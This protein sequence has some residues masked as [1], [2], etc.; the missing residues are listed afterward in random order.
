MPDNP[1][2]SVVL[3]TYRRGHHIKPTIESVLGQTFS[4]FELIVVGDGCTDETESA[5]RSFAHEKITWRNLPYNTGSQT[6][7]NNEGTHHSRG[8]WICYL[9]HDDIWSPDHLECLAQTIASGDGNDFVVSGCIF[10]GPKDSGYYFV[11]GLFDAPDAPFVHFFPLTSLAHRRDIPQRIGGWRDP[12]EITLPVDGD[13]LL[14]AARAGLRFTSTGRITVH[15]FA[16][17][18][19]YLSYLRPC[20]DEQR[21]MMDLLRTTPEITFHEIIATSKRIGHFMTTGYA[22]FT[23]RVPGYNFERNRENKGINIPALQPLL[24]RT[25]LGQTEELRA[26]DWY[27]LEPGLRPHRWSGPNPRPKL[28]IPFSGGRA[29]IA[30]EVIGMLPGMGLD[31]VSLYVEDRKVTCAFE[32]IVG[33]GVKMIAEVMLNPTDYTVLTLK[34]PMF[35]PHEHYETGDRRYLGIGVADIIIEP[36]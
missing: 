3:A 26:L 19:R 8:D 24:R 12:R 30:I 4:D 9:G 13:F 23:S 6:F 27:Y 18:H 34:T 33:I 29:R 35:F 32:D 15:K 14:R 17:G 21:E 25:V 1:Y 5:V 10:Y 36:L 22:E 16:A 31:E 28:L 11:T 7:P 2:F 20:S